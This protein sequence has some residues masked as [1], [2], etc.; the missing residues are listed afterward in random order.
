MTETKQFA[1]LA[2]EYALLGHALI[3]ATP[4]DTQAPYYVTRWGWLRPIRDL[5]QAR[6]LLEQIKGSK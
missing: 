4:G 6:Q 2:A 3:R 5:D 1:T